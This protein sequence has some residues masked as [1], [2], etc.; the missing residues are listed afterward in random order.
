MPKMKTNKSAKR[1]FKITGTGKLLRTKGMKSH[2]RRKKS[3]RVSRQFDK[4][5]PV[6]AADR[7]RV[8]RALP[9]GL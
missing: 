3:K 1:R 6:S 2:L 7:Q 5:Q 9:Y 4:M 8:Q